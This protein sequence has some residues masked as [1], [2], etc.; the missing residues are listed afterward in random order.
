ME[1]ILNGVASFRGSTERQIIENRVSWERQS[2]CENGGL[3]SGTY[4]SYII[5][6]CPPPPGGGGGGITTSN[7]LPW[8]LVKHSAKH[9]LNH[10]M[11]SILSFL[12]HCTF[13]FH[14]H[15]T[16]NIAIISHEISNT[17][18]FITHYAIYFRCYY[19][20][21]TSWFLTLRLIKNIVF[22]NTCTVDCMKS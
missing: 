5:H 9:I 7:N 1:R 8:C 11:L 22:N 15:I 21:G 6:E 20:L 16:E 4:P 2:G 3:V 14:L 13:T 17:L 10:H 18:I 12:K 19:M